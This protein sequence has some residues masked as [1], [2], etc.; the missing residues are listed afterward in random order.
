MAEVPPEIP[1]D[2]PTAARVYDVM[3]NGKDNFAIDRQVAQASLAIM[4]ELREIALHNRTMLHRVVR[5]LAAE[6]GITQF[7]DLGSGLPTVR[8]THEVAHEANP[9]A[10]VV[11]VDIDPVV[12]AH[13]RAILAG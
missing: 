3:L 2:V 13:G 6:E 7:L 9:D 8:N 11:Y 10:H 5:Y 12:L 1:T 4:P